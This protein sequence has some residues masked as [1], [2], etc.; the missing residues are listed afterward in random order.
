MTS[1]RAPRL[2]VSVFV[3][4]GDVGA[5]DRAD[6]HTTEPTRRWPNAGR[7]ALSRWLSVAFTVDGFHEDEHRSTYSAANFASVGPEA[8]RG[9]GLPPPFSRA[10][11]ASAAPRARSALTA[12]AIVIFALFV[13]VRSLPF[14]SVATSASR[15]PHRWGTPRTRRVTEPGSET[16]RV[17]NAAL[18]RRAGCKP[19]SQ[20]GFRRFADPPG[21]CDCLHQSAFWYSH[22]THRVLHGRK[23]FGE[24]VEPPHE[25]R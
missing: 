18:K 11:K 19:L 16:G 17:G 23:E 9:T 25:R 24:R 1:I 10:R 15:A 20:P 4:A 7:M 12:T 5:H 21:K 14:V 6:A 8:G 2:S 3:E 22:P 13:V